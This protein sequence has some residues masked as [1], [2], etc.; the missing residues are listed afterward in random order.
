MERF[1]LEKELVLQQILA[2]VTQVTLETNVNLSHVLE[3]LPQTL[4]FALVKVIVQ[5]LILALVIPVTQE[6]IAKL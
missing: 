2:L 1:V 3:S 4:Q 5:M 6:I